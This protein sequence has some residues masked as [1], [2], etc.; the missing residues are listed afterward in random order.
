MNKKSDKDKTKS[1][2]VGLIGLD[3]SHCVRF[4]QQL[5]DSQAVGFVPGAKIVVAY[6]G[7]S[8]DWELS[9]SRVDG[10]TKTLQNSF[11]VEIVDSTEEVAEKCDLIMITSVDGRVH[12][13]Q[14]ERV[15]KFRK[16]IFI[17]KPLATNWKDARAMLELSLSAGVRWFSSS[18]WRYTSDLVKVVG[19]KGGRNTDASVDVYVAGPWPLEPGRHGRFWYGIHSVEILYSIMGTGCSNVST[20][21]NGEVEVISG[22]WP[23]GSRGVISCQH[24]VQ[25]SFS[26]L[27]NQVDQT[28]PFTTVDSVEDRYAG[29]L[30]DLVSF[31]NGGDAPVSQEETIEGVAFLEAACLSGEMECPFDLSDVMKESV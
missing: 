1:L 16:P 21:R 4:A 28:F 22:V 13:E 3:S 27:I 17:D 10:F 19:E 8:P 2:R 12:R 7:G 9:F 18:V 29:L 26:G 20:Y 25:R 24:G 15:A 30:R 31:G 11:G 5:N 6:P 14:F 23:D